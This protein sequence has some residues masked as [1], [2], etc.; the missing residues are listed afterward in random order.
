MWRPLPLAWGLINL[1]FYDPS[2]SIES[3][4][5]ESGR[6]ARDKDERAKC[7]VFYS[8]ADFERSFKQINRNKVEYEEI[9][10]IVKLFKKQKNDIFYLTVRDIAVAIG[11]DIEDVKTDYKSIIKTALLE[12]QRCNII[13]R[14]NNQ[15]RVFA[16]SINWGKYN[17]PMDNVHAVLDPKLDIY[18]K[19]YSSMIMIMQNIVQNS[20]NGTIELDELA[21]LININKFIN[22]M[23]LLR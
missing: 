6:G 13:K 23:F 1:I 20:K 7:I 8:S 5:Q 3:Y 2:D 22:L 12:L 4:V 11:F 14:L 17:N 15:T 10:R 19:L 16:T 21:N 18:G 9:A